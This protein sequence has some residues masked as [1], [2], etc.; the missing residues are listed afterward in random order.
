[1]K[2]LNFFEKWTCRGF[3]YFVVAQHG[4]DAFLTS[5]IFWTIIAPIGYLAFL[6]CL[7][8]C[9][10]SVFQCGALAHVL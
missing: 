5:K 3:D 6:V 9:C 1:M 7:V 2:D 8:M 10:C 4:S